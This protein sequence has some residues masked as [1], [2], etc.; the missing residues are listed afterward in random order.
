[1]LKNKILKISIEVPLT[2]RNELCAVI[3]EVEQ[4]LKLLKK[5]W[6]RIAPGS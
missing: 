5:R 4:L 1:M 2:N 3:G 6:H